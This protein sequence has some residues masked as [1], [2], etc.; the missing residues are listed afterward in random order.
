M[1]AVALVPILLLCAACRQDMHN[2]PRYK[3]LAPSRFFSDGR[4]ARTPVEGTVA[5]GSLRL[6][7]AMFTGRAG[8]D[9]VKASPVA[10]TRPMLDRGRERYD[11]YCA[12][13]HSRLGDGAG[14]IVERGF[15]KPPSFHVERLRAA[16]DGQL[17]DVITNGFGAMASYV[18]RISVADRWAVVAYVRAL[19]LSQSAR[20]DEVPA[21]ERPRLGGEQ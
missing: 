9:F 14:M 12:P 2:Q 20:I 1:R 11:I 3:P 8:S 4:S 21:A 6:D 19:Q 18:S 13:C 15:R 17:F 16:P 5:R 7:R 10:L